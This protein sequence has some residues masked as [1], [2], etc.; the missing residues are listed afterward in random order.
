MVCCNSWWSQICPNW[1]KKWNVVHSAISHNIDQYCKH[2]ENCYRGPNH[3]KSNSSTKSS[4]TI[5]Q[6]IFWKRYTGRQR[7]CFLPISSKGSAMKGTATDIS[8]PQRNWCDF[9]KECSISYIYHGTEWFIWNYRKQ[10][11]KSELVKMIWCQVWLLFITE[12][13]NPILE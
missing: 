6:P 7:L 12:I 8:K 3:I 5:N 2:F 1:L 13:V 4:R 9:A 10:L 11:H